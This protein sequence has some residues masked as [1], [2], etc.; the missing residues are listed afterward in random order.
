MQLLNN[1][2]I[3]PL[4]VIS[5]ASRNGAEALGIL[6]EVGTIETGK[7]ADFVILIADPLDDIKN[8]RKIEMVYLG[9]SLIHS[10][11]ENN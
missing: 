11:E 5:N 7:Q 6:E 8:T 3:E 4:D 1:A 10:R 9:G 2:G